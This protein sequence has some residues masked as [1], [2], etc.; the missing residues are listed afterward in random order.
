[1]PSNAIIVTAI[2]SFLGFLINSAVM[3]LV[4]SRGR[5]KYHFLFA[6]VLF[7]IAICDVGISLVM[8]RNNFPDEL[9]IYGTVIF[10]VCSFLPSSIASHTRI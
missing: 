8:V 5:K 4:L 9:P 3:F 2:T 1:M 7:A 6:T 10:A